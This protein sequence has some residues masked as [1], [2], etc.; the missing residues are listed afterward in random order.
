[1]SSAVA[2]MWA[3]VEEQESLDLIA[4]ASVVSVVVTAHH[5]PV[6]MALSAVAAVV[7]IANPSVRLSPWTWLAIGIGSLAWQLPTW[8]SYDNHV[9]LTAA[10]SVGLGLCL[11]SSDPLR[12]LRAEGRAFVAII[13]V[14]G[15]LWKAGAVDFRSGDFFFYALL[16]DDRFSSIASLWGGIDK[17]DLGLST[18]QLVGLVN[19][20]GEPA[21]LVTSDRIRALAWVFTIWGL[22]I[23]GLIAIFWTLPL[24]PSRRWLRHAS[25]LAFAATTY[26]V[27][28]VGGFGC[29][30]MVLGLTQMADHRRVRPLYVGAFLALLAWGPIWRALLGP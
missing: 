2:R 24:S 8:Y 29:L 21:E 23:E 11:L 20:P 27:V 1:M 6:L 28:P 26:L 30:L 22:L 19:S 18:D 10:W 14:V 17:A 3:R 16:D 12:S 13:F 7:V 9:W 25:L 15:G 5:D 4:M